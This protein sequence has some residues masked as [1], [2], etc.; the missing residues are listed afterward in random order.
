M[1]SQGAGAAYAMR[2][3]SFGDKGNK[4]IFEMEPSS[5]HI[6]KV[7]HDTEHVRRATLPGVG[8]K[9]WA[10][11]N[12]KGVPMTSSGKKKILP[13]REALVKTEDQRK[14]PPERNDPGVAREKWTT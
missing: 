11:G 14:Q 6:E 3:L 5:R 9:Q 13:R 7:P 12:G 8:T 4:H 1:R 2:R 10:L